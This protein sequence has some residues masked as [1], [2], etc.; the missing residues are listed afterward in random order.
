MKNQAAIASAIDIIIHLGRIRDKSRK[1]LEISE[2]VGYKEGNIQ[3]NTLYEFVEEGE[4]EDKRVIGNLRRTENEMVNK[5]K[6]K[7]AGI[8]DK[9]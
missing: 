2:V 1:V 8:Q 5:L 3:L 7:M 4:T 6:F 9:V